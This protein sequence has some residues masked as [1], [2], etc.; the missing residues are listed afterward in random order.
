M[1][2]LKILPPEKAR[3]NARAKV[4][5]FRKE[6]RRQS[7]EASKAQ[8]KLSERMKELVRIIVAAERVVTLDY[9]KRG[10]AFKE[11][12]EMGLDAVPALLQVYE[13]ELYGEAAVDA[14][15]KMGKPALPALESALNLQYHFFANVAVVIAL[16]RIDENDPDVDLNGLIPRTID[17]SIENGGEFA[18]YTASSLSGLSRRYPDHEWGKIVPMLLD[19]V[20]E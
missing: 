7:L 5:A 3:E 18:R 20:E 12:V 6:K 17:F 14:I 4:N 11:L 2:E 15:V 19:L 8:D 16:E 1:N 9:E 13:E 10:N